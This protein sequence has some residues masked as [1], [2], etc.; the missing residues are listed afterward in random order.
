MFLEGL[1]QYQ[2]ECLMI[3]FTYK[4]IWMC[5]RNISG[6]MS[7][8]KHVFFWRL[9]LGGMTVDDGR[10]NHVEMIRSESSFVRD[11]SWHSSLVSMV[12]S[13]DF[14]SRESSDKTSFLGGDRWSIMVGWKIQDCHF[15]ISTWMLIVMGWHGRCVVKFNLTEH[16]V[17]LHL[18]QLHFAEFNFCNCPIYATSHHHMTKFRP[19]NLGQVTGTLIAAARAEAKRSC[20]WS[21]RFVNSILHSSNCLMSQKRALPS[22]MW[23]WHNWY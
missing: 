22:S 6:C 21:L 3:F 7:W 11:L 13:D 10:S 16:P 2:N 9:L 12:G 20:R 23:Y 14:R 19:W 5:L 15:H 18:V 17:L 1:R 8:P 4:G